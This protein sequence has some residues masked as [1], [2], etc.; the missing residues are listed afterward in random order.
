MALKGS[1]TDAFS[2]MA[3]IGLDAEMNTWLRCKEHLGW[4]AYVTPLQSIILNKA[5]SISLPHRP[6]ARYGPTT[7]TV[8]VGN[9]GTLT[10]NMLLIPG[11]SLTTGSSM[12]S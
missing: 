5:L 8:I 3:N 6:E 1:L 2:S 12:S 7:H 11:R 10:G 9:C 4:F